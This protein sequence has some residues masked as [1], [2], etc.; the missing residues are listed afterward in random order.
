MTK[1]YHLLTI[2]TFNHK[3]YSQPIEMFLSCVPNCFYQT[4]PGMTM[5][6]AVNHAFKEGSYKQY[7]CHVSVAPMNSLVA[8]FGK[9]CIVIHLL[10]N[11]KYNI[12]IKMMAVTLVA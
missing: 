10:L 2:Y 12:F 7:I 11:K 6:Y 9:Y 3:I 4:V 1:N 5:K 8:A